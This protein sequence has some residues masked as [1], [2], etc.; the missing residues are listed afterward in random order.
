MAFHRTLVAV[1]FSIALLTLGLVLSVSAAAGPGG[2]SLATSNQ[3]MSRLNGG[4]PLRIQATAFYTSYL[5]ITVQGELEIRPLPDTTD[6]IHVFNDQLAYPSM[7]EAQYQFAATHYVGTQKVTRTAAGR[8]RAYNP[9]FLILH[10]RLGAGLGY[11]AVEGDCQ[12]TGDWLHIIEG[13]QW[14]QEW[15]SSVQ[16]SWF[17]LWGGQRVLNCDWSWYLVE[18]NDPN[19]RTWWI[20]EVLRQLEA[21]EN[22]GL[23][24]DSFS[25]PNYLGGAASWEPDLPT[26]IDATFEQNW[27]NRLQDFTDY[28]VSQF[29]GRY[30]YVPNV[31]SWVTTRD[32]TD[33]SNVDGVMIEGFSQWG[34]GSPFALEDWRLQMDRI[35]GLTRQYKAII[36][37]SYVEVGDVDDRMFNLGCYLLVK[38]RYSYIN[39][40]LGMEPEYFPEYDIPIGSYTGNIPASIDDLANYNGWGVYGRQYSNGLVLVNP[41]TSS[42]AVNLGGTYYQAVPSGGGNIPSDGQMPSSWTVN[43]TEVSNITLEPNR[44]AILLNARP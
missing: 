10:Y 3:A 7:S 27:A 43:Y 32:P 4:D 38:G 13:D 34:A 40:D 24:A 18:L 30:Y 17:F 11:R 35:L 1:L 12:P 21:N 36:A 31:G 22:D 26:G 39:L 8:L 41:T 2:T 42:Q 15:P 6:G 20:G 25:V 9:N 28:V 14:V 5:P 44:A 23:F 19:W 37:Q 16:D 33:Y 29:Q